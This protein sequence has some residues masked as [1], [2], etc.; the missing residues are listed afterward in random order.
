M[1]TVFEVFIDG[2]RVLRT[3]DKDEFEITKKK[4]EEQNIKIDVNVRNLYEEV[5]VQDKDRIIK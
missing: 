5:I 4:Y 3:N 2:H 1:S